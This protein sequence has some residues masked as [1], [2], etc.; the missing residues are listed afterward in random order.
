MKTF[1]SF[2]LMES[3]K[4][5]NIF[6]TLT[7]FNNTT[8]IQNFYGAKF[9]SF[10]YKIIFHLNE[11]TSLFSVKYASSIPCHTIFSQ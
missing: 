4:N 5:L 7:T 6:K 1:K 2:Q 11:K 3:I 8:E 9:S 10:R